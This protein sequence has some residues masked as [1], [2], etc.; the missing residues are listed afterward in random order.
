MMEIQRR[1]QGMGIPSPAKGKKI[2]GIGSIKFLLTNQTYAGT[3]HFNKATRTTNGKLVTR[4]KSDWLPVEVPP[5]IDL[6]T[7]EIAKKRLKENEHRAGRTP[8]HKYLL[9]RRLH[10]RC[11]YKIIVQKGGKELAY[12]YYICPGR[13]NKELRPCD[14]PY[15]PGEK[16]DTI[17]WNWVKGF[18][19]DEQRLRAGIDE[20]HKRQASIAKP[21]EQEL[22]TLKDLIRE[23]ETKLTQNRKALVMLE[24]SKAERTKATILADIE[25]LETTLDILEGK[26]NEVEAKLRAATLTEADI[27][28]IIDQ[29]NYI[30]QEVGEGLDLA[31]ASIDHKKWLIERLNVEATLFVENGEKMIEARCYFGDKHIVKLSS[32]P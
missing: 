18:F 16:V 21:L 13:Q 29:V 25:R 24:G 27:Q 10:C 2:W 15:F 12:Q 32:M 8:K 23:T 20:Y 30:R 28:E 14:L 26:Q 22:E 3:W 6:A 7:L 4:D 5:I 19:D 9:N 17:I 11:G 1:L 31:N